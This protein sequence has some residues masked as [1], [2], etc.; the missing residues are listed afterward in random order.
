MADYYF[1][2]LISGASLLDTANIERTVLPVKTSN[3][4]HIIT[5]VREFVSRKT[6]FRTV[7]Q[8]GSRIW[9]LVKILAFPSIG[10][11]TTGEKKTAVLH[12]RSVG[13]R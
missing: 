4:T 11:T 3:P 12:A 6:V 13:S 10:T 2:S 9:E 8:R 7:G 5:I 1:F